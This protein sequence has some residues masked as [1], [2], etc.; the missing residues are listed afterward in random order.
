MVG[1][2]AGSAGALR[3]GE[4]QQIIDYLTATQTP[5]AA[6]KRKA[7][8]DAAISTGRS[9]V[10]G[11]RETPAAVS[12]TASSRYDGKAIGFISMVCLVAAILV[13]RR[14]GTRTAP[15][16]KPAAL[17]TALPTA[18]TAAPRSP[19][20]AFVLQL[21]KITHQTP[22]TKTLRFAVRSEQKLDALPG[23]FLTFT[24]LFDG[25]RETRCYSI[26]SSAA[27]SGYVEITPKRVSN[28]CVSVFLNDR[29]SI[30][31]T[32]EARGPFGEFCLKPAED[33]NIVLIA[34]GSGITPL[35][36]MLRYIDDLCLDTHATLLYCVRTAKDIIF[37]P[38]LEE[39]RE[40]LR[41]FRYHIALSQPDAEWT[42][43]RGHISREFVLQ[44]VPEVQGRDFFLCGPPPFMD[45]T[46]T[47]LTELG[48]EPGRIRREMFGGAGALPNAGESPYTGSGGTVEFARSG[49]AGR[50]APG[51]TVLEV[52][53]AA[54]VDIPSAC[55]QGQCGTCKTR[56]LEGRVEM[57]TESGL[58]AESKA[59]GFVL[60]CVGRPARD[61]RLDA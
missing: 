15:S 45:A 21:V 49:K 9:L 8:A 5:Q 23:Q 22:D 47:I 20:A 17:L 39:L 58:D 33:R 31:L 46:L 42:G 18:P 19:P 50:A 38:E 48:V 6:I 37:R 41:N 2:A 40:R 13:I 54:G 55:R 26:C 44:A 34:G 35:I 51:Q 1:Y 43:A 56:L 59:A 10:A 4:D 53:A 24:F 25:R 16:V 3:A 28:G 60:T 14:P 61:V 32:V 52:A 11:N 36:G 12:S 29:A 27:R 7:E 57:S 30:G